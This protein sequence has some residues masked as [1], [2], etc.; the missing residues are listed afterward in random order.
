VNDADFDAWLAQ[1]WDE[2]ATDPEGV[3]ARLQ[4][5]AASLLHTAARR[6]ALLHLAHHV[7]GEHLARWQDGI[8]LLQRLSALPAD[9]ADGTRDAAAQRCITSLALAGGLGDSRAGLSASDQIRVTAMAAASLAAH[10][11]SRASVLLQEALAQFDAASLPDSDACVR[12]LAVGSNNLA[13]TLEERPQRNAEEVALM[14]LAARSARRFWAL[15]GGWLEVERAEYR[16]AMSWL[17]AGSAR[18]ARVHAQQCLALVQAQPEPGA[19]ALEHFFAWEAVG[20]A[21]HAAG[22]PRAQTQALQEAQAWFDKLDAS[23]AGW[24]RAS[25]EALRALAPLSERDLP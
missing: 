25:L 4:A 24:C 16:L 18:Q 14:L 21:E 20:K 23:D 7:C 17:R 10:D 8:S 13:A 15:A 11:A 1:A 22:N 9:Q 5:D 12:A 2:H 6:P 19:P 3:L